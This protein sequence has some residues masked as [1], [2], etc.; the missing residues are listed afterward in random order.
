M[1]NIGLCEETTLLDLLT[2][3][4]LNLAEWMVRE[5]DEFGPYYFPLANM[6]TEEDPNGDHAY[7]WN[8]PVKIMWNEDMNRALIVALDHIERDN[9]DPATT[10]L[11]KQQKET[12]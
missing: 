7:Y 8:R 6:I 12:K 11:I 4:E 10:I 3:P 9:G 1:L 5:C 2:K